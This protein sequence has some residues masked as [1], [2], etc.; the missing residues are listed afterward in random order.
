MVHSPDLS[1]FAL[2]R[3]LLRYLRPYWKVFLVS[4]VS[5]SIAAATE[6]AFARL[7]K[8]LIDG[9]FV[10][11]DTS[12]IVWTPLA[13]VGL[14]LVRGIT[15]FINEYTSSWLTGHL[16]QTLREEMFAKLVRLPVHYYD[17]NASGRLLS[18]IA[19]DVNLVTE[20][21]FNVIT[22][23]VK[24]GITA[25]GLLGLLLYTDWQL[26]M[27]CLAV[28][29]IVSLCVRSVSRRLRGLSRQ[30]QQNIA[31]MTQIL[32]ETIDCQRVV[33]VYGGERYE[34]GRFGR[35]AEAIR[36]NAVKQSAA[37]SANTGLTQLIIACALALIL[38]FA[39]MRAHAG[40]FT[41][42]DFMS[43]LTAMLMLFAPVKRIT[44]I[45]QSLQK[46][47]AAA[48]SVFSFLDEP[49]ET[50]EGQHRL[51]SPQGHL[52]F[53]KVSFAY[54]GG[55]RKALTDI[56][57]EVRPGETVALV[58]SSGSGK[59][60][61]VSL[62]PRFYAPTEGTVLLDGLPLPDIRLAS[63]RS[64]IALV[65]QDV[66]LFNDTIAANIAYGRIGEV[67]REAI[68]EAAR[69]ANALEFIEAM[70]EGFDTLIGEN[71]TR[72]SG[73]QRQ[74][75]AIARALLKNAPI[76]ILDEATSALDTQSERL[77]Q[78][79]LERLMRNRTTIVIA[80]RLST[81]EN[82]DRIVVMHQGRIAE[83]GTHAELLAQEGLYANLHRLQFK[84]PQHD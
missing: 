46:G 81:I 13:I 11:K 50:D 67:G 71:G 42:G 79:A 31:Q 4:L 12:A 53:R 45:S 8:P 82:A 60:T 68:V 76:L 59:T 2:Y 57:F 63:L 10:N 66:V 49:G 47:L 33:K 72:L 58:G 56:D 43:F 52:V 24:D 48:E 74:R 36:H 32:G 7:M 39:A 16:V 80:H 64:H 23:T 69:A 22:V 30:N 26:T 28:L 84:E 78:A 77:V 9:G 65:S 25:L 37:S 83:V 27:I 35:A 1:G 51:T 6:P 19:F 15:S 18:R 55:E 17:D 41:A 70:P 40:A 21:G 29:P 14:F 73:G 3:R 75:L 61:L 54:P 20:A 5:M 62:I 44:S 34:S 38:Y